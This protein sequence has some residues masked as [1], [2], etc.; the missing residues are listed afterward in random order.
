MSTT[1]KLGNATM[2]PVSSF[3]TP[4]GLIDL[5]FSAED[6]RVLNYS[7]W[8]D[9]VV[10]RRAETGAAEVIWING[11][12]V[13]VAPGRVHIDGTVAFF[14]QI[15]L[16]LEKADNSPRIDSVIIQRD[17]LLRTCNVMV[18]KGT[19]GDAPVPPALQYNYDGLCEFALAD[20]YVAANVAQIS[21]GDIMDKR[22]YMRMNLGG[23][24]SLL[25][26]PLGWQALLPYP[27]EELA[28]S[29]PGWIFNN[30][31]RYLNTGKVATQLNKLSSAYRNAWGITNNGS[32]TNV[33]KWFYSDGRGYFVRAV[34]GTVRR[35][36][37]VVDDQLRAITGSIANMQGYS[38]STT[39]GIGA[40]KKTVLVGNL[41][42]QGGALGS[43]GSLIIDTSDLGDNF[44]GADSHPLEIGMTPATYLGV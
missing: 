8:T 10:E 11:L 15:Q 28:L 27:P 36:G 14:Q 5:A 35:V 30:G 24:S 1:N 20:V 33:P 39:T 16:S 29:A 7:F 38:T 44:N 23:D 40:L 12:N 18:K 4:D 13:N 21:A 9:G 42:A 25:S 43:R 3:V 32:S 17:L 41:Y 34:D 2:L 31:D 19:P 6:L 22:T 26:F 37:S